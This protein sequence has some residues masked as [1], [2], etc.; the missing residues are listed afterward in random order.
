MAAL[1]AAA[2]GGVGDRP[3]WLAAILAD[4]Y[5]A[6]G[7]VLA[8]AALALAAT[9]GI[10][11][12]AGALLAPQLTPEARQLLLALALILQGAGAAWRVKPPDRLAGWRL[13]AMATSLA[14]LFI[15]CFGDGLQF[16]VVALAAHSPVPAL[17]AVGATLGGFAV[18]APAAMLGER[19]WLR[20]PLVAAR[21]VI[22]AVFLLA[23]L[24]LA[25]GALRLI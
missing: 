9:S 19:A 3:P 12:G 8:A 13:G 4:R 5:R 18:F 24:V 22:G 7:L 25:L 17:A 16:V 23:G 11:A 15:L 14:G 6:P 10:A 2:L 20:L 1:V 21:R